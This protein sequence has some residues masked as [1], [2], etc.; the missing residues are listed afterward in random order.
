MSIGQMSERF[1][2]TALELRSTV[3][4]S[5]EL[6]LTL[7]DAPVPEP[8]E[9]EVVLR[10]EAAPL[11]PSDLLVLLGPTDATSL[12]ATGT[13]DRPAVHGDVSPA[14]LERSRARLDRAIPVGT[15]GAGV[16]V[17]AG[18]GAEG[19]VGRVVAT[20]TPGVYAEYKL[21]KVAD[22]IVMPE[23]TAPRDA[24]SAFINPLTVLGMV[25]TM[26]REGFTGIV[27]TAAASNVGQMLVRLC[28]AE[29]IPLVNV[30]RS[31]EQ[32]KTLAALGARYVVDSSASSFTAALTDAVAEAGAMLGFDAIGGGTMASTILQCMESAALRRTS[33]FLRYGT[34][35]PKQVYIYGVL[36]ARPTEVTRS[37]GA[38]WGVGGW[39]MTWCMQKLGPEVEARLRARIASEIKTTFATTYGATIGL[40][41]LVDPEALR[42]ANKRATGGKLLIDPSAR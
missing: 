15:E 24:A 11:N 17:R 5:G 30:V 4:S 3:T 26:R 20:R 9:G 27:H 16:V 22:C 6:R 34:S 41:A 25:E 39:L 31:E 42:A 19:L 29:G 18:A 2:S 10:V 12:R 7:E 38:A 33:G 35:T 21:A 28:A 37:Y 13:A 40:K 14:G 1:P 23:G 8:G 36:D 32:A